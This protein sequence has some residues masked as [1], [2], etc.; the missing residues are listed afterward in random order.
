MYELGCRVL[1]SLKE[2]MMKVFIYS[3]LIVIN[4]WKDLQSIIKILSL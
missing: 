3:Q 4:N 1:N 2:L